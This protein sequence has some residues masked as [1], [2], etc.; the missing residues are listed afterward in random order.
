MAAPPRK[1]KLPAS[2][3]QGWATVIA[4]LLAFVGIVISLW[5]QGSGAVTSPPAPSSAGA[6][7][8]T[9]TQMVSTAPPTHTPTVEVLPTSSPTVAA[10]GGPTP[11]PQ[12]ASHLAPDRKAVMQRA[13]ESLLE[14]AQTMP[15]LVRDDFDNNDY[16]W[17]VGK[18]VYPGGIECTIAIDAGVF[19][20]SVQSG[21][22]PAFC[23]AGLGNVA[24]N[25]IVA[26]DQQVLHNRNATAYL[27]YRMSADAQNF[28][29]VSYIPQ[30]QQLS[31]GVSKDGQHYPIIESTYVEEIQPGET[32]RIAVLVIAD[33]H[34][35]YM[36]N[37]LI[38]IFTDDRLAQGQTRFT[39]ELHEARQQET[40]RIDQYELRGN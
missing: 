17:P 34:A 22:G 4:G 6:I 15:L 8:A 10:S 39:I 11:Q 20:I 30:T 28:Y 19:D 32:N 9:A 36:N 7:T 38:A 35:V 40:L 21:D 12:I 27:Y 26:A 23:Y 14:I 29:Y 18:Y 16:S 2:I 31:I 33:T 1:P 3:D 25:F 13:S 37:N 24:T 5:F